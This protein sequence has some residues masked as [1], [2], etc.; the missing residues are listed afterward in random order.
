MS[1]AIK[2]DASYLAVPKAHTRAYIF[3]HFNYTEAIEQQLQA[4]GAD[5]GVYRAEACPTTKRPHLQGFLYWK[6][7]KKGSA[8]IKEFPG[9]SWRIARGD[10][11]SNY[12]Y[13][14]KPDT[15]LAETVEWG[16]KPLDQDEKGA[17]GAEAKQDKAKRLLAFARAGDFK[18]CEEEDA[19][20]FLNN[21]KRLVEHFN[22][23]M[24]DS[25]PDEHDG[26]MPGV[27][28]VGPAGAGK[29]NLARQMARE[30]FGC[31]KPY[32]KTCKDYWWTG[33][34][35]QDTIILDDL[36]P[37]CNTLTHEFKTW[38]DRYAC[39]VR[40]HHG[41][42]NINPKNFVI[43]SQYEIDQVFEDPEVAAAM[44]RR[45]PTIIRMSKQD[46]DDLRDN[47]KRKYEA[48]TP[49]EAFGDD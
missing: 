34:K 22:D 36:D 15:A 46:G 44:A 6:N 28:I 31:T 47:K 11:S 38:I 30:H 17:K 29:S 41:M 33:Y 14:S 2:K 37:T 48:P 43:T 4:C 25:V 19:T 3:T 16:V 35:F 49:Q 18:A 27:W 12:A 13:C 7:K 9:A 40:I 10:V 42:L 39:N 8:L 5:Y 1:T 20:Y 45:F 24:S 23:F 32:I 26:D 21:K